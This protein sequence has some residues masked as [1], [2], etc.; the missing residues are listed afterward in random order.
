M[1]EVQLVIRNIFKKSFMKYS[2]TKTCSHET[3]LIQCENDE[4][5]FVRKISQCCCSV[6]QVWVTSGLASVPHIQG[7]TTATLANRSLTLSWTG[8]CSLFTYHLS[9]GGV[10]RLKILE[11]LITKRT[12]VNSSFT[13]ESKQHRI[14]IIMA[15][16][17]K[18]FFAYMA[19]LF[20][21]SKFD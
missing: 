6:R 2:S 20:I 13:K 14:E 1:V 15:K 21:I 8:Y 5:V 16:E 18:F 3:D 17:M 11:T 9:H 10:F 19:Y 12:G 4:D 7:P